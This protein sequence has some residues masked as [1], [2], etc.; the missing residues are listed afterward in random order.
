MSYRVMELIPPL[1]VDFASWLLRRGTLHPFGNL[2]ISNVPGPRHYM[3]V[4]GARVANWLSSGHLPESVGLN[5]TAWSYVDTLNVCLMADKAAIPE[6]GQ[7]MA[8]LRAAVGD[9]REL[10]ERDADSKN[11]T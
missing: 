3:H 8:H 10:W 4:G 9:Y 7:F 1:L 6:G 2:A 11:V 5:I